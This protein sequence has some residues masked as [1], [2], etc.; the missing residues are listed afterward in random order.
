LD[1]LTG[2]GQLD[3]VTQLR[4]AESEACTYRRSYLMFYVDPAGTKIPLQIEAHPAALTADAP[5][6]GPPIQTPQGM[7]P[8][9]PLPPADAQLRFV[10]QDGTLTDQKAEAAWTW[11]PKLCVDRFDG[12]HVRFQPATA[13]SIW[14]AA[15]VLV[16]SFTAVRDLKRQ[17]PDLFQSTEQ[18]PAAEIEKLKRFPPKAEMLRPGDTKKERSA[19]EQLKGDDALIF[20]LRYY[21]KPNADYPDGF[22]GCV[23]GTELLAHRG[24]FKAT[25]PDGTEEPLDLPLTEVQQWPG[26]CVMDIVGAGNDLRAQQLVALLEHTDKV[27]NAKTYLPYGSMVGEQEIVDNTRRIIPFNPAGKPEF[28]Q[29]P[30][31]DQ[32]IYQMWDATKT[33]MQEDVGLGA[34][35]E[36]LTGGNSGN[37]G[38]AKFA[39][40]GQAQ[41]ALTEPV[42]A[43]EK[44]YTRACRII[45]QLVRGFFTKPQKLDFTRQDGSYR[46]RRWTGMDLGS[47]KDVDLKPGTL[48]MLS[49]PQKTE[50]II[51]LVNA[52]VQLDPTEVRD[53]LMGNYGPL[54]GLRE[55]PFRLRITRQIALWEDGP[56]QGWQPPQP[57]QVGVDQ[58]GQP[59]MGADPNNALSQIW[60]P[61]AADQ[62]P[63]VAPLRLTELAKAMSGAAY[64]RWPLPWRAGFDQEFARMQQMAGVMTIPQQQMLA[65]QQQA[66]AQ[67]HGPKPGS[68]QADEKAQQQGIQ[69][70]K[71]A[72]TQGAG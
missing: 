37:S 68:P 32:G 7:M 11:A 17:F 49:K 29:V 34:T 55:N 44:A 1:H 63:T 61:V 8:S 53:S 70:V 9:P 3:L 64:Q 67:V 33:E 19:T 13:E 25:M 16:A 43:L 20:T 38:R 14:E 48:S 35:A 28:E 69:D 12:R 22:Y 21:E 46:E 66:Q 26:E 47:T 59:V 72:A 18:R 42:Q 58:M 31:L 60:E 30:P 56:P 39:I 6:Q 54:V 27:L 4:R 51:E 52:G 2:E 50:Q 62:L 36:N 15:G 71:T 10:R 40:I 65:A 45:L 57:V 5:F 23:L 41:V 24:P